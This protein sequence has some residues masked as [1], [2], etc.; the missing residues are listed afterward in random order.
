MIN[1]FCSQSYMSQLEQLRSFRDMNILDQ[2]TRGI[3]KENIRVNA[4]GVPVQTPHPQTLGSSLC[5]PSITTDFSEN[6]I[7]CITTP[8]TGVGGRDQLFAQLA[9]VTYFIMK[10]LEQQ[11]EKEFLWP[12]SMPYL[13]DA[14]SVNEVDIAY[15]GRSCEGRLKTI[16]RHGLSL[17]YGKAMQCIAGLH[18]NFSFPKQLL[19]ALGPVNTQCND[20]Q[21]PSDKRIMTQRY[22]GVI[23]NT[24][25]H[26][27]L[28][29]CLWGASPV[30]YA[31]SLLDERISG[32]SLDLDL[33]SMDGVFVTSQIPS[34]RLSEMGYIVPNQ[35]NFNVRYQSINDYV[36]TLSS[37]I[38]TQSEQFSQIPTKDVLGHFQQIS[39][40][41]LQNEAEFYSVIRPKS[42]PGPNQ[43]P[44]HHLKYNGIDYLEYR[45]LDLMPGAPLGITKEMSVFLDLFFMHMLLQSTDD[46]DNLFSPY[47]DEVVIK[48]QHGRVA[49]SPKI[50]KE[51]MALLESMS[52]LAAVMDEC[53]TSDCP[54]YQQVLKKQINKINNIAQLPF[55]QLVDRW[56]AS[57][58][59]FTKYICDQMKRNKDEIVQA[60]ADIENNQSQ[61][62]Q[63]AEASCRDFLYQ[64]KKKLSVDFEQYLMAYRKSLIIQ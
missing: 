5:N 52:E 25:K 39:P 51:A 36:T 30:C 45:G 35:C 2:M 60:Y 29:Q 31:G 12:Y 49:L 64:D 40:N 59:T 46:S 26:A 10:A 33:E 13:P 48:D 22:L 55:I 19:L 32:G 28:L 56:Q 4:W 21:L 37:I 38:Q 34:L 15:Y 17:R 24:L 58:K 16:Y 20:N 44:L 1:D 53:E 6:M 42:V 18:Y 61:Y 41:Q 23:R 57:S 50:H 47:L 8:V 9:D 43:S 7:E 11:K 27:W 54:Q 3:E 62:R 14:L 63:Q